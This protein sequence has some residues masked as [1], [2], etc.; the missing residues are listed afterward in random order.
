MKATNAVFLHVVDMTALNEALTAEVQRLKLATTE[1]N[2]DSLS[3]KGMVPQL[4]MNPQ[5]YQM[6]QQQGPP[7]Q[8]NIP[9]Q[10]QQAPAQSQ[11]GGAT[12]KTESNQ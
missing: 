10:Q 8:F 4:S 12:S 1:L 9:Q 3:S 11:N 6:Q 2:G 5:I 7:S